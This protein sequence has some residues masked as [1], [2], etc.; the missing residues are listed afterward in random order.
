[1]HHLHRG[2]E[3]ASGAYRYGA[4]ESALLMERN[5]GLAALPEG[6]GKP[7]VDDAAG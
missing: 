2:N 7:S 5:N 1:M 3:A 6:P 4:E